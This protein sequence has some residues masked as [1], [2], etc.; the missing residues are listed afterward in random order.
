M[1]LIYFLLMMIPIVVIHELGH[2]SIGRLSGIRP[3]AFSV[4][5]GPELY[6]KTDK[7]GT[8]WRLALLPLGGYVR[9]APDA[10]GTNFPNVEP[11][12]PPYKAPFIGKIATVIAGPA[13]NFLMSFVLFFLFASFAGLPNNEPVIEA[14]DHFETILEPGD[15][16][17][18]VNGEPIENMEEFY[19][20][21]Q[22]LGPEVKVTF[23]RGGDHQNAQLPNPNI[24]VVGAVIPGEPA[25]K[26]GIEAGDEIIA[27]N[28]APIATRGDVIDV[29]SQG[30]PIEMTVMRGGER[31]NL[32]M[33]AEMTN[34]DV[35]RV[36]VFF[37]PIYVTQSQAL[38]PGE[39]GIWA[40]RS[41]N[42][43]LVES[44]KGIRDLIT[45]DISIEAMTGPVGMS[46]VASDAAERGFW[47]FI[48]LMG[49]ISSAIGFL[50]LL[51]IP[52]LD[53]G[54]VVL[55]CY[56][57]IFGRLPPQFVMNLLFMLGIVLLMGVLMITTFNEVFG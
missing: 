16:I 11:Q 23:E 10:A 25:E 17:T 24:P 26:A 30:E 40:F 22:D 31:L 14:V 50:N 46:R 32:Q 3:E 45:G 20:K 38:P 57:R 8:K 43:V 2:Y 44:Y 42:W 9:F 15:R 48:W 41:T 27:I 1:A 56:E 28:G 55:M 5:F 12:K 53:G 34:D 6:A 18:A 4:G 19:V 39:A 21:A 13:F 54:H 36:G 7:R 33:Q 35:A 52:I 47:D 49:M 51:P 37:L 29:V